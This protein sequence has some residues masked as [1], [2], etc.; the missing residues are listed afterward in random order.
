[1]SDTP[2]FL[3]QSSMFCQLLHFLWKKH[4]PPPPP[5]PIL[6]NFQKLNLPIIRGEGGGFQ[7]CRQIGSWILKLI[8]SV[9]VL[10]I[11]RWISFRQLSFFGYSKILYK[12]LH[13]LILIKR[14]LRFFEEWLRSPRDLGKNLPRS[15]LISYK[16]LTEDLVR[17]YFYKNRVRFFIINNEKQFFRFLR[18]A[19]V[20]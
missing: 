11:F 15:T 17:P 16:D 2:S 12:I 3:K 5:L 9:R 4:E 13:D 10:K 18:N 7:L 6:A 8:S 20:L 19:S 1:M 14:Q